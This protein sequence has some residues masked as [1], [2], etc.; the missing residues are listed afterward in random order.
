MSTYDGLMNRW[1]A[2]A[3]ELRASFEEPA[4]DLPHYIWVKV[5]SKRKG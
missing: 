1:E 2:G 5:K 3:W 4:R